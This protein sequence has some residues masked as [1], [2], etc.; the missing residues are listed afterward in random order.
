MAKGDYLYKDTVIFIFINSGETETHASPHLPCLG[1][2]I[3]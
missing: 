3:F 1:F 2:S